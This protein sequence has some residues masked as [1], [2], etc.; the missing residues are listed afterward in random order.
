MTT[1]AGIVHP[2]DADPIAHSA[3]NLIG[4]PFGRFARGGR[5]WWSPLRVLVV[6]TTV[7]YA[8]GYALDLSCRATGWASPERY[9][10]LCYSDIPPLYSLRGFAD[11]F[12][13]YLQTPPGQTPLEYPV[14]TG[15]FMQVSAMITR[16][17][18]SVSDGLDPSRTFFDVN[19]VLL[20]LA[21]LVAVIATALTVKRRPWDAAM[22]AL[23]PTVILAAT[24]N[25]D[26]LPLAFA[27][28]CLLLWS[29]SR[30]LAAGV[31]LGLAIAA[32]FYP[33]FFL[34]AFLVLT[35]RS[36]RWR[37]FGL[38]L[39]GT[40]ASWLAV[41]LPFM[42]A[43]SE[44]WS[45]FYRFSQ[46]RGEDFGSIW[47]AASQLGIGSIPPETLN[48]VASGL[49]LLLCVA[50]GVLALMTE[51]RPRLAQLLF[52]IVAAFAVTNK[53]YSPQ[54]VLWLV[55]LAAMARPR[56]RDFI[57]WQAGEVVYFVAIWWFLVGYGVTDTKGMTPQWYAVATF[58]HVAVTL[59]FAALIIRDMIRPE[60]DPVRT[61]GF[62]DD[63][64]DPGGGVFDN[65]PD[66]FTL[67]GLRR[68]RAT[69]V[70]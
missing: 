48:V 25:W 52:L 14:I 32:K 7:A 66:V 26:L 29:R 4:G 65:A 50:I 34:G 64:D 27:G 37:A 18:T 57:V 42:L 11:G 53:V 24:V 58:I 54:Y 12:I 59:W 30:P 62:D 44:G 9:E 49:F 16:G 2:S 31:L 41:N 19:V 63:S 35:L 70:S 23:A 38:L 28:C 5:H 1:R 15:I 55:P 10:H 39:L 17:M 3:S 45:F 43:N 67:A 51:R 46:E 21:L 6:F 36:G 69:Q 60:K 61:D 22:V 56:W 33:L 40:A 13:P 68:H 20:L 8:A 47:F